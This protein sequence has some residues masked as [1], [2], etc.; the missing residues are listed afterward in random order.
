M[1]KAETKLDDL[2]KTCAKRAWRL[3][4][5]LTGNQADADDVVQQAF[6]VCAKKI[7]QVPAKSP[8]PWLAAVISNTARHHWRKNVK[9]R[10]EVLAMDIDDQG[11][12]DPHL[13]ASEAE[14]NGKLKLALEELP[15]DERE[16]VVMIHLSGL[17]YREASKAMDVP[18]S[19]LVSRVDNAVAKLRTRMHSSEA[20]VLSSLSVLPFSATAGGFEAAAATWAGTAKASLAAASVGSAVS[21]G[22]IGG[23]MMTNKAILAAGAIV[24]LGVGLAAGVA[25]ESNDDNDVGVQAQDIMDR[26][27]DEVEKAII[28]EGY[29]RISADD[30]K[31]LREKAEKSKT[32]ISQRE[33]DLLKRDIQIKT[34]KD[35]IKDM[36]QAAIDSAAARA[37]NAQD[38][39]DALVK[40]AKAKAKSYLK[41]L[42]EAISSNDKKAVLKT[43]AE[44]RKLG[45]VTVDEYFNAY[46]KVAE[47]GNAW[48]G[49]NKLG[50]ST[51]EFIGLLS[52]DF[53]GYALKDRDGK[54]NGGVRLASV[55]TSGY[56]PNIDKEDKV[57]AYLHI[58]NNETN[59]E[60]L[61]AVIMMIQMVRDAR[62]VP[63]LSK[64]AINSANST[65][66]RVGALQAMLMFGDKI[67]WDAFDSL[68]NETDEK[69]KDVLEIGE[70]VKNPPVDGMLIIG[71]QQGTAASLV[72][73]QIGDIIT[74]CDTTPIL[75]QENF[76]T[77]L[78][79]VGKDKETSIK[80][81]RGS[82]I[83]YVKMHGTEWSGISGAALKTK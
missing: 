80:V 62:L 60:L 45:L 70:N 43:M 41:D 67:D 3:A 83:K 61:K 5:A 28:P 25:I 44:F 39:D 15:E 73:F 27:S 34:L 10:G 65:G 71:I 35:T 59:Q 82:D 1:H 57:D 56:S 20:A 76:E 21:S 19:T 17:S 8:W 52:D 64:V 78:R 22:I 40:E 16:A 47:V 63:G 14:I 37:T 75:T 49:E 11:A 26:A 55:Y 30:L 32:T 18:R 12:A 68:K 9:R 72:D 29:S 77:A 74:M 46:L 58:L 31:E 42:E 4:Y 48:E 38:D 23:A 13:S 2:A 7:D 66:I 24:C 53:V 36:E 81:L 6:V 54:V 51:W 33:A 69:I 50:L 79:Q